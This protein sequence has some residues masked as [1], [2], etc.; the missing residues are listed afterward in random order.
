MISH[1]TKVKKGK[2]SKEIRKEVIL[3]KKDDGKH[4]VLKKV[5]HDSKDKAE[6]ELKTLRNK[7]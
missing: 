3:E 1:I 2:V 6:K 5:F 7:I 4:K